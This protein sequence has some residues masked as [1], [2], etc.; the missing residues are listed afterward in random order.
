MKL[1]LQRRVLY[2]AI[3]DR[4]EDALPVCK[5][6]LAG[7]LDILEVPLRTSC[8]L[9][10]ISAI[11]KAFPQMHVGAGT[12]LS[13]DQLKQAIDAGATFGV[14]PG[15]NENVVSAARDLKIPFI[16]GVMT[17]TETD[18]ALELGCHIL[19]LFPASVLGGPAML[20]ALAA[21]FAHMGAKFIP[22]GGVS[23]E[24]AAEYLSISATAAIGGTWLA[25]RK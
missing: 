18:R 20:K 16:P 25:D 1:L 23:N 11:R 7:G 14:A 13:T 24:N 19:K 15:L 22:M 21:P 5:A 3:F 2:I 4:V 6:L 17:P 8:A 10:S 12:V 9:A